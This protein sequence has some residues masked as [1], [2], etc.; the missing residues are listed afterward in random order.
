M[1][2]ELCFGVLINFR[3]KSYSDVSLLGLQY[4]FFTFRDTEKFMVSSITFIWGTVGHA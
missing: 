2:D 1:S 4:C 3:L